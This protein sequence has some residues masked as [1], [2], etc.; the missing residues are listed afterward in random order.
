MRGTSG[1]SQGTVVHVNIDQVTFSVHNRESNPSSAVGLNSFLIKVC[2]D[3][4]DV[5]NLHKYN[6]AK[7]AVQGN[8]VSHYPFI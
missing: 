3:E 8:F 2:G 1:K 6:I 4:S 7:T 5:W